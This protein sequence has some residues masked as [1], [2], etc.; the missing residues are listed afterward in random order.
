[1]RKAYRAA[2][3]A[4][5]LALTFGLP[6]SR[7]A[8]AQQLDFALL[9][10]AARVANLSY[11]GGSEILGRALAKQ[12]RAYVSTPGDTEVQYF[13]GYNDARKIQVIGVRGTSNEINWRLNRDM[14][15]AVDPRTGVMFHS[16]FKRAADAI[17]ADV[18]P[19][20]KKGYRTY[21]TGHSMGGAVAAILGIYLSRDGWPLDAVI[22]FGQPKFTDAA[23]VKLYGSLPIIRVINQND[24]VS[25]LPDETL[26]RTHVFLHIG[27]AVVLYPGP[28]YAFAP[29]PRA[30][31][32][33]DRS[34]ARFVFQGS[35]P[36]HRMAFYVA[37]L[38]PKVTKAERIDFA[39]RE[40][41]IVRQWPRQWPTSGLD[42]SQKR[43]NFGP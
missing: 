23:G 24:I 43:Q 9:Y 36:D 32:F 3:A 16:G 39:D 30:T 1:M 21:L 31:A 42:A 12:S 26:R 7:I 29:A 38:R 40:R 11:D 25:L 5:I 13:I 28:Y 33:S 37:N 2:L 10:Q 15:G 8:S 22:T 35:I 34:F 19:R 27:K 20:L 14:R 4:I 41:F 6:N 17:Y 18:K